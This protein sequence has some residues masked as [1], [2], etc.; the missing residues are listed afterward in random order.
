MLSRL[1]VRVNTEGSAESIVFELDGREVQTE[2]NAPYALFGDN[3]R[4][5]FD[6][7]EIRAGSRTLTATAF[8]NRDGTG[9]ACD[10]LTV[11][12]EIRVNNDSPDP[13][14]TSRPTERPTERPT[15]TPPA[16]VSTCNIQKNS[17]ILINAAA[18]Q[19]IQQIWERDVIHF[20]EDMLSRLNIRID[21][22][23]SAESVV[24]K[25]DGREVQTE[26]GAPY[27]LFGDNGRG[28]YNQGTISAGTHELTATAFSNRDATGEVCDT[29]TVRFEI[30]LTNDQPTATSRPAQRP[31]EAPTATS[32]PTQR[33][34]YTSTSS[35]V[36][37]SGWLCRFIDYDRYK[38]SECG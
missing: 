6:Q 35:N 37:T 38:H 13:T 3:G 20:N 12:F 27:T 5:D 10:V 34:C 36:N 23:G 26:R 2:R 15:A 9:Q 31:T 19:E 1:N 33:H 4:G 28:D 25:L 32:R 14:A 11:R 17:F 21:A 22:E 8:P 7:G 30:K 24:F 18:N 16:R 29:L